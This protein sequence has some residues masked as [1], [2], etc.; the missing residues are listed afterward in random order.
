MSHPIAAAQPAA[1]TEPASTQAPADNN[2]T[3]TAANAPHASWL[4]ND[5]NFDRITVP[6][7]Q[8]VD[9]AT[10][11]AVVLASNVRKIH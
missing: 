2:A 1:V 8:A 9:E 7:L 4:D 3:T 10:P 6:T 11:T 5:Q